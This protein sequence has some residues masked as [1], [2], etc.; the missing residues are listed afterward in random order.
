MAGYNKSLLFH[1]YD[2]KLGLY[3]AVLKRVDQQGSV[4]SASI[5]AP[6]LADEDLTVDESKFRTF[7]EIIICLLYDF[8]IE[9]PNVLRVLAWEAAEGWQTMRKI[10]SQFPTDDEVVFNQL[11]NKAKTAGTLSLV[12]NLFTGKE[13]STATGAIQGI[14]GVGDNGCYIDNSSLAS[15]I[16]NNRS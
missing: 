2:D 3:I 4:L 13:R 7:L 5:L 10:V 6:L 1:Y 9:Y 14:S 12:A 11:L 16:T 15:L 8:F